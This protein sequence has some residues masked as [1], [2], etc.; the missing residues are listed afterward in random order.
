MCWC[1]CCL[2]HALILIEGYSIINT[3]L[4]VGK[5]SAPWLFVSLPRASK[6]IQPNQMLF[7][8]TR[9]PGLGEMFKF[10]DKSIFLSCSSNTL[11]LSALPLP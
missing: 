3:V 7:V 4:L 5:R 11:S 10:F 9:G 8:P 1:V 6:S 2:V